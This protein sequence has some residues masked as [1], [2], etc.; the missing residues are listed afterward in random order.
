M[1]KINLI[2]DTEIVTNRSYFIIISLIFVD[3]VHNCIYNYV[4]NYKYFIL[5]L[6]YNNGGSW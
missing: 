1:S 4:Q 3:N 6:D 5:N 2:L